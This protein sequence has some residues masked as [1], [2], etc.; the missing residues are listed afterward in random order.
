MYSMLRS[1]PLLAG[2]FVASLVCTHAAE[3]QNRPFVSTVFTDNMVLQRGKPNTFWGWAKPGTV[4]HVSVA[5][6]EAIGTAGAG[7]LWEAK[8]TP[9]PVGGP[10]T[11]TISG[12]KTVVLHNVLV[13]DVWLCTGQSNMQFGL[14]GSE[15]GA[16]AIREANHPE[17]RLL[18]VDNH[19]SYGRAINVHGAWRVCTP[20]TIAQPGWGGFSAV[21]YYFGRKLQHDLNVPIG[22]IQDCVG[23]TPVESWMSPASLRKVGGYSAKLDAMDQ[24]RAE[25]APAY[26]SLLMHWLDRYDVGGKGATW[27]APSLDDKDWKPVTLANGFAELG[28]G[29]EPGVAW[30]RL[31][32]NLPNPLPAGTTMIHFGVV[33]KMDTVYVNGHWTGASSWVDNPRVYPIGA[34]VLHPGDNLIAVRIFKLAGRGFRQPDKVE[35]VL[36]NG[37]VLPLAGPW[38]AKLSVD[39]RPPHPLPLDDENFPTMPAVLFQGMI[40]PVAPLAIT[41]AIWYQGE[42]NTFEANRYRELL[43]G[44]I[45]DWRSLFGQGDFPFYIVSLPR[46][47]NHSATPTDDGWTD[48][49]EAQAQVAATV[50]NCALAVTVDT[51]EADNIHPKLKQ[52]VGE[53]LA[54]CALAHT[55][56]KAVVCSGPVYSGLEHLPG[57]LKLNFAHA[58]GGLA[59][60]GATLGEFSVAG[61][62]H[63]WHWATAKIEGDSVI[64]S[65]P[66]V[67]KPFAARYAW[68][69]NPEA[70]LYNG[71]GLPAVPF[72]TDDWPVVGK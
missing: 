29:N 54:L 60:H 16:E 5:G 72:R 35:L 20:E 24:L 64:V 7:G 2:L 28:L 1:L 9:P 34:G 49:R 11:V 46:F 53:R 31:H 45:G 62:D 41:G 40:E 66:E 71:A 13:G 25:G 38:V 52:P 19:V 17:I 61:A 67:P 69:A 47:M 14:G 18:M 63:V 22:L 36:G 33:D 48:L 21:A 6:H 56:H 55:Y 70:T 27:G 68:Q 12:P 8:L 59:V 57:A 23:G 10:Y 4:V 51:G 65:C 58:D 39:A 37:K 42:S 15:N 30:F 44:M 3:R 50:P 32:I 43:T 26:G